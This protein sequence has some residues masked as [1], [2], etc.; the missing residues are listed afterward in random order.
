MRTPTIAPRPR[1][2]LLWGRGERISVIAFCAALTSA[3][4]VAQPPPTPVAVTPVVARDVPP[5]LRVVGSVMADKAATIAAEIDGVVAAFPATEGQFLEPG[6]VICRLDDTVATLRLNE[7]NATLAGLRATLTELENGE[8]REE[9][10]R[11]AA[12]VAE[13]EAAVAKW[14]F[15]RKRVRDLAARGQGSDKEIHDTEMDYQAAQQRLAQSRAQLEMARNGARP[16]AIARARQALLA[17]EARVQLLT[18]DLNK[19]EVRAP[20]AGALVAK[21]TEVGQW[22]DEG[23]PVCDLVAMDRVKV[24]VDVP[25]SAIAFAGPGEPASVEIEALGKTFSGPITRLIPRAAA[26]ART[27]PVEI[28]LPNPE[29]R[30]L[31]GMFVRAAVPAGP[32]G[33][34]TM[35]SKDAIVARGTSKSV[36]VIRPG[37]GGGSM[38]VPLPVTTGLELAGEIEVQAPGLQAGDLVVS[39]ANERLFG[40]T[41]VV[42]QPQGGGEAGPPGAGAT[43]RPSAAVIPAP[44]RTPR[45]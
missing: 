27:F 10:E 8:R 45:E 44:E 22:I 36:Y 25:E 42:P 26:A 29:H 7:A 37:P 20:F 13:G 32:S 21:H 28:E 14:E 2:P 11:L 38:A 23:G 43:T 9:L 12:L 39:R 6:D 19:T 5:S 40:P 17:Q 24:R 31:P 33:S 34:R 30:L 3:A 4:A 15:E 18:R 35:V 41:P 16:E 1:R